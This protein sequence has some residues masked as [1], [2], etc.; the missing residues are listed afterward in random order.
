MRDI[1]GRH[2]HLRI[3]W[4][5]GAAER[6]GIIV[7]HNLAHDDWAE[8]LNIDLGAWRLTDVVKIND[9]LL[10]LRLGGRWPE[11]ADASAGRDCAEG[12]QQATARE[13]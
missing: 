3:N 12:S 7:L 13:E 8:E 1:F 2:S 11:I 9:R 10:D 4:I 6:V 5:H